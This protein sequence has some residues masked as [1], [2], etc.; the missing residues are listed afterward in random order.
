MLF[1]LSAGCWVFEGKSTQRVL[2]G[3]SWC[4]YR[5]SR[6]YT[7]TPELQILLQG[8]AK[9]EAERDA[10]TDGLSLEALLDNAEVE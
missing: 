3:W 8:R 10:F 5:P 2:V 4:P 7:D 9:L 6:S 1:P